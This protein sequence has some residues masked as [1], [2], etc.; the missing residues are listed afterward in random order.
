M[1]MRKSGAVVLGT[2]LVLLTGGCPLLEVEAEIEEVCM[3]YR[4]VKVPAADGQGN[5]SK[6]F[7]FDDLD[8]VKD[9][10]TLDADVEFRHVV[11]RA[12]SG[13]SDFSFLESAHVTVAS[14]DPSSS[15]P[16][17]EVVNCSGDGCGLGTSEVT[18]LTDTQ[19]DALSYLRSGSI[20]VS[21]DV[22]GALPDHEWTM[23]VDVCVKGKLRFV[24]EL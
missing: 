3:T 10:D 12:K 24:Q 18:L 22:T 4:D 6:S 23:D 7:V 9:L 2:G 16:A 8:Q 14:G 11:L 5:L 19:A 21:L 15:L 17:L 13:V 1:L 20:A